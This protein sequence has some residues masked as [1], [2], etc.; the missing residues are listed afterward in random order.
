[1]LLV[2]VTPSPFALK[3]TFFPPSARALQSHSCLA[4]TTTIAQICCYCFVFYLAAFEFLIRQHKRPRKSPIQ[5][6]ANRQRSSPIEPPRSPLGSRPAVQ[7][8]SSAEQQHH[9]VR[10]G[11]PAAE[12]RAARPLVGARATLPGLRRRVQRRPELDVRQPRAQDARHRSDIIPAQPAVRLVCAEVLRRPVR[13]AAGERR[14]A[15]AQETRR[16]A[17]AAA[18]RRIRHVGRPSWRRRRRQWCEW[19]QCKWHWC[20]RRWRQRRRNHGRDAG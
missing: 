9:V 4:P 5:H 18:A 15:E 8:S 2:P 16:Q 11:A 13:Q 10:A 20:R 7:P 14:D 3:F 17:A 12:A 6:P 1:M 19:F